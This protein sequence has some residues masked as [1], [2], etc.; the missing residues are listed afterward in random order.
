MF[1][2]LAKELETGSARL[3]VTYRK[4]LISLAFWT[5]GDGG[6][7]DP[8]SKELSTIHKNIL[9]PAGD[10]EVAPH[11]FDWNEHQVVPP[12]FDGRAHAA[13]GRSGGVLRVGWDS[14]TKEGQNETQDV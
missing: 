5:L 3:I 7:H 13:F 2:M 11:P 8:L 10:A 1:R 14:E 9:I 4:T 12:R 6:Q